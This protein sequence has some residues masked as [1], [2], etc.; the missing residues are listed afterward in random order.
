MKKILKDTPQ[1]IRAKENNINELFTHDTDT[2]YSGKADRHMD[3]NTRQEIAKY[4]LPD[5]LRENRK[6]VVQDRSTILNS[7]ASSSEDEDLPHKRYCS[8]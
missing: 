2:K 5:W 1:F 6:N 8:K 7:V 3:H 4:F